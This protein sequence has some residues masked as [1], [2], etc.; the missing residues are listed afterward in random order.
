MQPSPK[1]TVIAKGLAKDYRLT[2]Q[3]SR[4]AILRSKMRTVRA[5]HPLN[6]VS[7]AGESIGVLGRNLSLI[8]I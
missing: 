8:H 5:L 1:P 6:F 2:A 7:Y 4:N 3:G